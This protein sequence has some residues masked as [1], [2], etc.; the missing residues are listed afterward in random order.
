MLNI[1]KNSIRGKVDTSRYQTFKLVSEY[2]ANKLIVRILFIALI[3]FIVLLMMPWTQYVHATGKLTALKPEQRPQSLHSIISGRIERWF[4]NEGDFVKKGDT[5][6]F[7]SEI[8]DEYFDPDLLSRTEQQLKSKEL[9]VASYM[10]KVKSMD[11]QIDALFRTKQLK[12]DQ[13]KNKLQQAALKIQSDSMDLVAEVLNVE[14]ANKQYERMQKLYEDGL[15][16]LTDV[17]IRKRSAQEALSKKIAAENKLLSSRNDYINA[18]IELSSIDNEYRDKLAKAEAEK[19]TALSQMYDSEA[20]VTKM[21]N[22]YINYS[23]RSGLYYITAPQDGYITRS[24][25]TG[26]G[27]TIKEGEQLLTIMPA[28]YDLGV[29][30]FIKPMD[31]PLIHQNQEVRLVFDGWP[32]VAFSGWPDLSY[33]TYGGKVVAIDNF[34]N[35]NGNYRILIAPDTSQREWPEQLRVGSG[36][37]GMAMLKEVAV[38]YELWRKFNGF[39]PDFYRPETKTASANEK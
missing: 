31:L 32:A 14:I 10:D 13:A 17:E 30:L 6:L 11:N 3:V 9:S 12:I 22:Q 35:E 21:Q 29:E 18:Q 38:G 2:D 19:Y 34:V 8:K 1:S 7:I 24:I 39:P 15:K 33:G 16:S 36:A 5:I 20:A 23:V 4:V 37:V 25:V 26:I 27:E 28:K